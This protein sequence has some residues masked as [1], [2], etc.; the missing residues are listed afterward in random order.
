M[1]TCENCRG[2]Y[3]NDFDFEGDGLREVTNLVAFFKR[4]PTRVNFLSLNGDAQAAVICELAN[5]GVEGVVFFGLAWAL[6]QPGV[7]QQLKDKGGGCEF[8]V[9]KSSLF[10]TIGVGEATIPTIRRFYAGLGMSD[11]EVMRA[12]DATAKLGIRF[13]DWLRPGHGFVHP[14]GRFGQ[15]LRGVEFHHYWLKARAAGDAAPLGA[16]SLGAMLAERGHATVPAPNPPSQLSV[17]DWAL[18]FDA[19]LFAAHMRRFA[20]GQG[21]ERIDA[22]IAG[23]SLREEDGFVEALRLEDGRSVAGDLF[24][25]AFDRNVSI[26][27]PF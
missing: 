23:V 22:R 15:D 3:I 18:H 1:R 24:V 8:E 20:Q 5:Q 9:L 13:V 14:F 12:C 25:D 17:F 19:A 2:Y 26:V 10:G 7:V 21:V 6:P 4:T 11:A 27:F 16:Y